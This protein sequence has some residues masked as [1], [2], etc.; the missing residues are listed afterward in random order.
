MSIAIVFVLVSSVQVPIVASEGFTHPGAVAE[1]FIALAFGPAVG[2]AAAAFGATLVDIA[3]G[4][5]A[6]F[7][8]LTFL[9]H[10]A[11]GFLV[12]TIGWK[13]DW[14]RMLVGWIVGGLALVAIYFA[15]EALVVGLYGG[16]VVAL[17][18]LP[19]NLV[20]VGL[21]VLGLLLLRLLKAAY[22]RIDR[23]AEEVSFEEV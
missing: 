14:G 9:A 11:F 8:P 23:L 12:G 2:A 15:G 17:G 22:P 20:Q 16:Y 18:E 5:Y 4:Q 3:S 7:A 19:F 1:V 10:G 6:K 13:K 21:G